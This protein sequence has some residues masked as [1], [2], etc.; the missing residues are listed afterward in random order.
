MQGKVDSRAMREV[1]RSIVLDMI[2]RGGRISRTDLARRSELTKPTVSAIVE[3]LIADGVVREVGYGKSVA[4]GGR[5]ARL[6]EFNES[7]AA[8]LGIRWG[9]RTTTVAVSNARGAIRASHE[10]P[11]IL[12]R[13]EESLR[14]A[15]RLID[16]VL[17][18]GEIPRQ[19]LRSVGAAVSGLVDCRLGSCVE[20]ASL[21]WREVPLRSLLEEALG[22]PAIVCTLADAAAL[23]EGRLGVAQSYRTYAWVHWGVGIGAGIVVDGQVFQG[24]RGFS[25]EIG[26]LRLGTGADRLTDLCSGRALLRRA[27]EAGVR[28][29][30]PARSEVGDELDLDLVLRLA[31]SGDEVCLRLVR[32]AGAHLG[33]GISQLL[34]V[35]DPEVVVLGGRL[36]EAGDVAIDSVRRSIAEHALRPEAVNLIPSELG[37]RASTAGA[38][39]SAMDH[40]VQSYRIVAGSGF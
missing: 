39:L 3:D 5:R 38:V 23:A 21:G 20:S 28:G 36:A 11:A 17:A 22:I 40:S 27:V 19:L 30:S 15:L 37:A 16:E 35:L 14:T 33:M 4:T 1:N 25:G 13:P 26:H 24:H 7:S 6:L 29:E 31:A 12:G 32:E 9:A 2:R 18:S 8:Y 10:V 34:G